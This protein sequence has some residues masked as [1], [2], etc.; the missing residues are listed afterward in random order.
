LEDNIKA[1]FKQVEH[2]LV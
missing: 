2:W 1:D